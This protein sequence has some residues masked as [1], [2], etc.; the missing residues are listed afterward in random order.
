MCSLPGSLTANESLEPAVQL[1]WSAT[2]AS[3]ERFERDALVETAPMSW[4]MRA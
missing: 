3:A 1:G 2:S 4:R